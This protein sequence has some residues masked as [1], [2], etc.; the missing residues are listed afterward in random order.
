MSSLICSRFSPSAE[1]Q[2]K[3]QAHPAV[4]QASLGACSAEL[5]PDTL[6]EAPTAEEWR[7]AVRIIALQLIRHISGYG[8]DG[9]FASNDRRSIGSRLIYAHEKLLPRLSAGGFSRVH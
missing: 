9:R 8:D 5:M 7:L 1:R 2:A 4:V 6:W 3:P